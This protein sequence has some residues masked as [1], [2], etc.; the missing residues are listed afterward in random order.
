MVKVAK[1]VMGLL[2]LFVMSNA[3]PLQGQRN[4]A[5]NTTITGFDEDRDFVENGP[6][7]EDKGQPLWARALERWIGTTKFLEER[8]YDPCGCWWCF[9]LCCCNG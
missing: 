4:L 3:S 2:A 1:Y 6:L 5:K 8:Q 7:P 9:G